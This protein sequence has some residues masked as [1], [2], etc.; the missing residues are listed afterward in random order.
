MHDS[1]INYTEYTNIQY[2]LGPFNIKRKFIHHTWIILLHF[3]KMVLGEKTANGL[4]FIYF[5]NK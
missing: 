5:D 3:M 1:T 4:V 2:V